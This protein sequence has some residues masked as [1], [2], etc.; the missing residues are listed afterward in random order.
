MQSGRRGKASSAHALAREDSGRLIHNAGVRQL[1]F[2]ATVADIVGTPMPPG[3]DGVSF[4]PA[5]RDGKALQRECV[6]FA[7]MQG[8][9]LVTADG[10]KLRYVAM[11][12]T[13]QL[14]YLPNDYREERDLSRGNPGLVYKLQS[15]LLAECDGDL[16]NGHA[17]IQQVTYPN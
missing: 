15:L 3:K 17:Q 16:R 1:R 6:V 2:F 12:D 9:A 10:W 4:L 13:F 5:V 7:S 8:P 14:Y 11:N